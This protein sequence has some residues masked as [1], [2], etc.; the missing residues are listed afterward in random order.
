MIP[1]NPKYEGETVIM[2]GKEWILPPLNFRQLKNMQGTL[3]VLMGKERKSLFAIFR[4]RTIFSDQLDRSR[5]VIK[6]IHTALTRNYPKLKLKEVEEMIDNKS[7]ETLVKAV[8]GITGLHSGG[9]K[10]RSV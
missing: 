5:A 7:I 9:E 6:I 1:T 2:G 3:E 8:M 10:A 4:K